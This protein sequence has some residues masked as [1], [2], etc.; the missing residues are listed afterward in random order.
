MLRPSEYKSENIEKKRT[1]S[2]ALNGP[3]AVVA[4][5][6]ISVIAGCGKVSADNYAS[7][8]NFDGGAMEDA[9]AIEDNDADIDTGADAGDKDTGEDAGDKDSGEDANIDAGVADGG[10]VEAGIEAGVDAD[11][12]DSG[13]V[14]SGTV[15]AGALHPCILVSG[16]EPDNQN[17]RKGDAVNSMCIDIFNDCFFP[18]SL[19]HTEIYIVGATDD[20]LGEHWLVD[21]DRTKVLSDSFGYDP[22]LNMAKISTVGVPIDEFGHH[23][24]VCLYALTK[25]GA[26]CGATFHHEIY[27]KINLAFKHGDTG[28]FLPKSLTYEPKVPLVK[29]DE[30]TVNCITGTTF[31]CESTE[32]PIE[33]IVTAGAKDVSFMCFSCNAGGEPGVE[34]RS[35]SC[36]HTGNVLSDDVENVRLFDV[37]NGVFLTPAVDIN[38]IKEIVTFP[39]LNL[40][41]DNGSERTFCVTGDIT[42]E[43]ESGNVHSLEIGDHLFLYTNAETVSADFPIEGSTITI[44]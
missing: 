20:D 28:E 30:T 25:E 14:D 2:S 12:S 15:D 16:V 38:S 31:E 1:F 22:R 34:L 7:G 23:E 9:G 5:A 13:V 36:K 40:D 27:S 24:R 26:E 8:S 4:A 17:V 11:F 37:T 3:R 6:L 19:D 35:V 32:M 10:E 43:A 41:F 44:N 21:G 42:D 18:I 39:E 29:G 33:K